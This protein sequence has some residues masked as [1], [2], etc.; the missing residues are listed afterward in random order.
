MHQVL[1]HRPKYFCR[2]PVIQRSLERPF[3]FAYQT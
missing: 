1:L 3:C 2:G